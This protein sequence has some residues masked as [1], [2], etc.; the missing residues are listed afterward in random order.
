M[1]RVAQALSRSSRRNITSTRDLEDVGSLRHIIRI[2]PALYLRHAIYEFVYP[3]NSICPRSTAPLKFTDPQFC[4]LTIAEKPIDK[5]P[6][7]TTPHHASA[8]GHNWRPRTMRCAKLRSLRRSCAYQLYLFWRS[9]APAARQRRKSH[10]HSMQ[11]LPEFQ[12]LMRARNHRG[13]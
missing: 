10:A 5:A 2:S 7:R 12:T 11:T 4:A 8:L 6:R 1:C 3:R 13:H 9:T